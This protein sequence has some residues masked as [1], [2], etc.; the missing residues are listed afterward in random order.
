MKATHLGPIHRA[1]FAAP[2][3]K[4]LF[5]FLMLFAV[6]PS[7]LSAQTLDDGIMI[8]KLKFCTGVFYHYDYWDH[9]WEGSR[10]RVNGNIGTITTRTVEYTGNYGVTDRL[11]V[12]FTIPFVYT[13]ASR[14]VLHGQTAL[15]DLSLG[16]K[17]KAL[18]VPVSRFGAV[19][20]FAVLSGSLPITNYTPDDMPLS[21]GTHSKTLSG[22][23]ILNYLGRNGLY[24]NGG[25]AYTLRNNV[26]L[27]R[28][29]YFTNNQFYFSNQ[30]SMPNQF[31]YSASAGYR[32]D[33]TTLTFNY[34]EQQTR[35]GGDIRPQDVPFVSNR[36]NY[37]KI[38]ATLTYPLPRV[39][40]MQYWFIYSNTLEGR[41]VGQTNSFTTGFLYTFNF[42]KRGTSL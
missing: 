15:Q 9:Y 4:F 42:N 22:R 19:R 23:T 41:N 37:K 3:F 14:G 36:M 11:D 34:G 32:K 38:G 26:T 8:S 16:L 33:D 21:I 20:A 13:N 12:L 29:T 31:N 24:L 6:A 35:G 27:D 30:V 10:L 39:R 7:S 17:L 25:A 2:V 1:R 18:S 28:S 40:A 5:A